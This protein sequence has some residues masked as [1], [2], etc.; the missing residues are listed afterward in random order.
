LCVSSALSRRL[1]TKRFSCGINSVSAPLTTDRAERTL[2]IVDVAVLGPLEVGGDDAG[3]APRDRVVL[4]ALAIRPGQVVSAERLADALW[5]DRPPA[6]WAKVVQGCVMRLRRSIA[7]EAIE[8]SPS[9][10]RLALRADEIDASRFER[11]LTRSQELLTLG[12]PERAAYI[13]AEALALWRGR[14]LTDLEGWEPGRIEA[15]R[16]DELRLDAEEVRL[17]AALRAGRYREVLAE[18]SGRVAEAPLRERRWALLALAQYQAGRQGEA[19]RTLHQ[20]RTVLADE[21]G[22]D[23]GPD[24]VAMEQSILR[25][26]P[27]LAAE[28]ALAEPSDTCPY[29]GLV[30]YDVA[31]ADAFFG[32]DDEV[33]ACVHR[34]ATAGVL[35]VVGPS[36]S[37][38]SSLVR[39]GLAAALRRDGGQV[40]V[41]TPGAH[42]MDALTAVPASGPTPVLIVDQCEE[43]VSLC[44]DPAEQTRFFAALVEHTLRGRLVVALRADRMGDL[45]AHPA[46]A[47]LVERGLYLLS[48]MS[49]A[50]L[51]AAIEGPAHQAGFLVEAGLV[52]LLV[53][54]V[55]GEPGAL[56]LLSH[57]L[58]ETWERREG[59]TLT[60]A[61][62][63]E[64][65]GIRGSVAQSAEEVY[66]QV[67]LEQ[68]PMLRD[69]LLRL[70]SPTAEGEPVRS[71]VPRRLV[72]SDPE[73]DRLIEMLVEARLVTSDDGV[74]E[75]AHE[76]LAR[77]WPRLRGWLDDDVGGQRILRHLAGAADAWDH[78]HRPDSELYRG[79]RL[80][81]ALEWRDRARPDLTDAERAFLD[82][83]RKLAEVEEQTAEDRAR[84]QARV[85][86]RLGGLLVGAAVLLVAA[87]I[88][89]L[90]AVR[91]ADQA[92]E[93]A[94]VAD[95]RRVGAQALATDHIERSLLLAVEG[96]RLDDSVDT[97]TNLLAALSRSPQ[98][99]GSVRNDL[100]FISL[101]VSP[102]GEVV[103]AGLPYGSVEFYD[104]STL[105]RLGSYD[106]L[107]SWKFAFRPD[108]E[109]LA[110]IA[111]DDEA[112]SEIDPRPV[113]L[114][115]ATTFEDD[116]VQL[117]GLPEPPTLPQSVSYSADGRFLAVSFED[118]DGGTDP[119]PGFS[120]VVVWDLSAPDQPVWRSDR[121]GWISSVVFSPDRSL[122]YVGSADPPGVIVHDVASGQPVRST[123]GPGH[124]LAV[125]PDGT[126]LAAADGNQVVVVETATLDERTRLVGHTDTVMELGFSHDGT[127]LASSSDDRT[128]VVWDI[129]T[130]E[131]QEVLRGHTG[132][133]WG[134]GFSPDDGTLYTA[135]GEAL[136]IWDLVGDRRFIPRRPV[137]EPVVVT[138]QA[139]FLAS[140]SRTGEAVAFSSWGGADGPRTEIQFLDVAT[141]RTSEVIDAGH[142]NWGAHSWHPDGH[143]FA[144]T[145]EDGF[146][147]VWNGRTGEL[148]N[149]R[150]VASGHVAG[151]DY[152]PDGTRLVVGEREGAISMVDAD[153]LEP[154]GEPVMLDDQIVWAFASPD[155]RSALVLTHDESFA[156]VDLEDGLVLR[157]GAL[158]F[159]VTY[160]DF[161]PDGERFAAVG[162]LGQAGVVDV[163]TGDWVRPP[164]DGH[165]GWGQSVAYAPDGATFASGGSDGRISLWDG[166]TGARLATV[167]AGRPD[168]LVMAEFL[169]DGHTLLISAFDGSVYTWDTRPEH[170]TDFACAVAGRNLTEDEWRDAFGDRP[171]RETCPAA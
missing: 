148:V 55:E 51:R 90:L 83:G 17:D 142:V 134:L 81:Q 168:I 5:G 52:D 122:L 105:E 98:L 85:N 23:P 77:A 14:P 69:L 144:T 93:A 138:E 80:T 35:A 62:Y 18:A 63:R 120:S 57:A 119:P 101:E 34:L 92:D 24:L 70:V 44:D 160:A 26:D 56:P 154:V 15:G 104:T 95:A 171:Y 117:G 164:V 153:T 141:G 9:G 157:R 39:A 49:V 143:L 40:I 61:G 109:Q 128:V 38:K 3:L 159:D 10:Y 7:A 41:I 111:Q 30:P 33:A 133:V 19:L 25:Q 139:N 27:S 121:P 123:N 129:A 167:L 79:V 99:I 60:V 156:I 6:S 28:A 75:L 48:A 158:G 43:A 4:E 68:R 127:M 87:I 86:R 32:R 131:H 130:S 169:P 2:A 67:P 110:V 94:V 84:Q 96:V 8:T 47:R 59:G 149:E 97:R 64:T 124:L 125:S 118:H 106:E 31:D 136:R 37:G 116:Q 11:L 82:A 91:E 1:V 20:A 165:A 36:G 89:G 146:V 72:A 88:A 162:P 53:R 137:A 132:S 65:G 74:V 46:F 126:L 155:N 108:G 140:G 45:S 161:S 102:D 151:L 135:G 13:V 150:R 22:L 152:T 50:D 73:H 112:S 103:A 145:G 170:S 12:E 76:S 29:L 114:V 66:Q 147:R 107:S 42:P 113:R 166:R 100:V 58:R 78:L 21:L 163:E 115:D 54:D 71:R 16:L